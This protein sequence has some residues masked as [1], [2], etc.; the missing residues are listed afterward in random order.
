MTR[1][2]YLIL[3]GAACYVHSFVPS[4]TR[5]SSRSFALASS[6]SPLDQAQNAFKSV[7]EKVTNLDFSSVDVTAVQKNLMDGEFGKRGEGYVI[8]QVAVSLFLFVGF[9]P[10]VGD[11]VFLLL[12]P[13]LCLAGLAVMILGVTD[14]GDALSPWPVPAPSSTGLKT[15]GLYAQMR[16]PLYAGVLATAAGFSIWTG[17][18]TRLLLT[19]ILLYVFE[20]KTEYE[21]EELMQ[22]FPDYKEYRENVKGKFV[23]RALVE[24]MPWAKAEI[25]SLK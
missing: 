22:R 5:P 3:F 6:K 14:L 8:A 1:F 20:L 9:I 13:L 17:S 2:G 19:A 7:Q 10:I 15:S 18:A 25:P 16:H 21:E 23:P 24:Q 12:G 11:L 4:V